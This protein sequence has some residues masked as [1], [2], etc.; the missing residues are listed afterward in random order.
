[1]HNDSLVVFA[2][3]VECKSFSAASRVLFISPVAIRK[4]IDKL[5][6]ELSVSLFERSSKG[7][8]LTEK[9][10]ILYVAVKKMQNIY[11]ECLLKL[12]ADRKKQDKSWFISSFFTWKY[13]YRI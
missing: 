5:E 3:V 12:K 8:I 1:M 13:R 7:V 10:E 11:D 4:H 6:K 9:G 2:E